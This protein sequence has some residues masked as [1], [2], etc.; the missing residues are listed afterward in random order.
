[1]RQPAA[2]DPEL[3]DYLRKHLKEYGAD[4]LRSQLLSEGIPEEDIDSALQATT[5]RRGGSRPGSEKE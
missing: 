2:P 3:V 5:R 1:M 4:A